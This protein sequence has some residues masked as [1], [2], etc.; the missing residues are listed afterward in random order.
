MKA[1]DVEAHLEELNR[2]RFFRR[3]GFVVGMPDGYTLDDVVKLA[4]ASCWIW[5]STVYKQKG[6]KR[7]YMWYKENPKKEKQVLARRLAFK[8]V[9][10]YF[11]LRHEDVT[12]VCGEEMCVCPFPPH[13][14]V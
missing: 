7:P 1:K 5:N 11:P 3:L 6:K 2:Q 8:L 9:H 4:G 14:I 13:N 10:G 12:N